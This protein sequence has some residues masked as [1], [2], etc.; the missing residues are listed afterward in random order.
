MSYV[1]LFCSGICL[2][3]ASIHLFDFAT[4]RYHPMIRRWRFP[5][6]AS[7]ISGL[8]QLAVAGSILL[9][10][11]WRLSDAASTLSVFAGFAFWALFSSAA[12][13]RRALRRTEPSVLTDDGLEGLPTEPACAGIEASR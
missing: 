7:T 8:I 4:T 10:L 12:A 1:L 2:D 11:D 13:E 6:L 3:M 9:A 5:K